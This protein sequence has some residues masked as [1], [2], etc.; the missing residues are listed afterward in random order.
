MPIGEPRSVPTFTLSWPFPVA[1]T[2]P[3]MA[4]VKIV[5]GAA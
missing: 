4:S 5:P 3:V 1:T 2:L